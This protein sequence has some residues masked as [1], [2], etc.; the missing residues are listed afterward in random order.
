MDAQRPLNVTLMLR[1]PAEIEALKPRYG[2]RRGQGDA[3]W[4]RVGGMHI[5]VL[6]HEPVEPKPRWGPGWWDWIRARARWATL[7]YHEVDHARRDSP[8]HNPDYGAL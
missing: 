2:I 7:L 3:F 1:T 6:P 4:F 8:E 5:I